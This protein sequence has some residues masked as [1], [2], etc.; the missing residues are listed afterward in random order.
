MAPE[1]TTSMSDVSRDQGNANASTTEDRK[2][3][4]P[5]EDELRTK[6]DD[7]LINLVTLHGGPMAEINSANDAIAWLNGERVRRDAPAGTASAT[8]Q[9]HGSEL[10]LNQQADEDL[11]EEAA[12]AK[13]EAKHPGHREVA[14]RAEPFNAPADPGIT[15]AQA[16]R[17][18]NE[19]L[20]AG[21]VSGAQTAAH[22]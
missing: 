10:E 18:G 8:L 4:I 5:G 15:P 22:I 11:D 7:A 13:A 1:G 12:A 3:P 9:Q 6:T 16:E 21:H 20:E 19:P 14:G 2:P 17:N